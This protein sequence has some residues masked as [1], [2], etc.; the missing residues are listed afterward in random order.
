MSCKYLYNGKVYTKEELISS[1]ANGYFDTRSTEVYR[2]IATTKKA[3]VEKKASITQDTLTVLKQRKK[4]AE[5]VIL[6]IQQS[7]DSE[8]QKKT[9][10]AYYK[11]IIRKI[12]D[13]MKTLR[14]TAADK[15]LDYVFSMA[16]IDAELVEK[17]YLSKTLNFPEL[18]FANTIVETWKHLPDAL[19][20][21]DFTDPKVDPNVRKQLE[22]IYS[23]YALLDSR[24]RGIA[25]ELIKQASGNKL[26]EADIIKL[27][28][29]SLA[30]EW[31]RELSTA[32]VA[33]TNHLAYKLKEV[34]LKINKDHTNNYAIID[35]MTAGIKDFRIF[36]KRQKD[37][38][39]NE[40]LGLVTRYSQNFWDTF[41]A[42]NKT[43]R[44][45]IEDAGDD[46]TKQSVAWKKFHAWNEANTISFNSLLFINRD[47]YSDAQRDAEIAKM[48]S[49]GFTTQ[50]IDNIIVESLKLY[51][52]FLKRKEEFEY[53]VM[54]EAIS[55]PAIVPTGKTVSEYV[56]DRVIEYDAINNPLSYLKQKFFDGGIITSY[57]GARHTYLI[58]VKTING[59][60]SG[61]YDANF[62]KI[63]ADPK[64]YAFYTWFTQFMKDNLSW[65]PQE[66]IEDLQSNFLPVIA[67]R[68]VKEYGYSNLKESV[69]GLGDWFLAAFSTTGYDQK[70]P[71]NPYSKR[72]IREFGSKFINETVPVEERSTDLGLIA[73][74]FSDMA[75]IYK[76][77]NSI[78]AEVDTIND[79]IQSTR[80][81][82]KFDKKLNEL[83]RQ[84][85]DATRIQSL[86]EFT[87]RKGFYGIKSESELWSSEELFYDW[88]ELI[89]ILG[90]KS[91]KAK[92]AQ[93]L[94]D[95][96]KK[97]NKKLDEDDGSLTDDER[98]KIVS[99]RNKLIDEFYK[100]GGRKFSLSKAI[101]TGINNTRLIALG[102]SPF[103]AA[104]N[105]LVGKINNR[106]HAAGERDFTKKD[107]IWSN[108]MM[109]SASAKYWSA[110]KYENEVTRKIFGIMTDSGMIEG[111][112]GEYLRQM[113]SKD[114]PLNKLREMMPKAYTWL[115][116]G[117]YH[118]KAEMTLACMK[119]DKIKTEKGEEV[120]LWDALTEDRQYNEAKYGPWNADANDGLSFDDFFN[121]KM[122]KYRQLANKLHGAS[123]KDVYLKGK[124]SA[125]G[126][127]LFLF[128]TWLPETVGVRFDPRHRDALLDRDEEGY[129]RTFFNLLK[130]KNA[131]IFRMM[132]D[133]MTGGDAGIQDEM[134][135]AN[136][137]K[138][139]KEIQILIALHVA[140]LLLKTMAPDDDDKDRKV[141]NLLLLRQLHDLN[142]DLTYYVSISSV[143]ELQRNIFP[144][145][146]TMKNYLS[147]IKAASYY[148]FG[149]EDED[150]SLE[151][152]GERTALKITKILPILSNINRGLYY[153]KQID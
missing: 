141:Y 86:A 89:P 111:P 62:S 81:S 43:L 9:K 28:D 34:N 133:V 37:R 14:E 7:S 110:G 31:T 1:I 56:K 27:V 26:T 92:K 150:G 83:V 95:N 57:G 47:D 59:K 91:A 125:F 22:E 6:A 76:H 119:F 75:L 19:G 138:A 80:G 77:K 44:K 4:Q 38:N 13:T 100:L 50:E 106:V 117:D 35:K 132:F 52:R 46:K 25:I 73:K 118:F 63:A 11:N 135:L 84:D 149:V 97:L 60:D 36:I 153:A 122:L 145:V 10:I 40:T 139:I 58:P 113:I 30:T 87:V 102:L 67:D 116:G 134:V 69:N 45:S 98:D 16:R 64:L 151:Y 82:Y 12:Y 144:I 146:T 61:Y 8:K 2:S 137:K 32:G 66:E 107:L 17:M 120:S 85:K 148:S 54:D 128:K 99:A 140:Y 101:D 127:M 55:N 71:V 104:R 18:Q 23:R 105:L 136:F 74:M 90:Y 108:K 39:G 123:G 142:R 42:V 147:A 49:L 143:S 152:D 68:L 20:L 126:R 109:T 15:Q 41:R 96:I 129:Y 3:R 24:S 121:K 51:E 114:T 130:E 94:T 124:D 131:G 21:V 103:S 115:S 72:E 5:D 33:I 53:R 65:L 79:L 48:K 29:T 93:E 70:I 78:K 88:K 112:D